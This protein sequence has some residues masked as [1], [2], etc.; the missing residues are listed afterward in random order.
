MEMVFYIEQM[1]SI[2][3]STNGSTTDVSYGNSYAEGDI[4]GIAL[5]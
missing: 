2:L 4:I 5:I 1:D 3:S